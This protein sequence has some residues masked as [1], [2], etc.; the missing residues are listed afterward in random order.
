MSIFLLY[1]TDVHS[2]DAILLYVLLCLLSMPYH[3]RLLL[4]VLFFFFSSR[5][6]HT[7]FKC[8]WSSDVCSSDLCDFSLK[9]GSV[10]SRSIGRAARFPA[11]KR[12]GSGWRRRSAP[13]LRAF[14]TFWTS[15]ALDCISGTMRACSER[16]GGCA[17]SA[18]PWSWLNTMK[19]PS[20][21][22]ITLLILAQARVR[23]EARSLPK[24]ASKKFFTPK[25]LLP[26]TIS[27]DPPATAFPKTP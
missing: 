3:F 27:L 14:F 8:D 2:T 23:G 25:I 9:S 7:R 13:V 24:A 19:K 16:C 21:R 1:L 20:A 11:E 12:N 17:I 26:R 18:I 22:P 5:R 15:R 10:T 4:F 6:R